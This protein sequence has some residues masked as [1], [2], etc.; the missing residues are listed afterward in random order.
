MK[1]PDKDCGCVTHEG[2]HWLHMDNLDRAEVKRML[3]SGNP[4]GA[5][6]LDLARLG[7]KRY[8]MESRGLTEVPK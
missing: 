4:R 5:I 3:D 2:P 7:R 8:E 1:S 6:V